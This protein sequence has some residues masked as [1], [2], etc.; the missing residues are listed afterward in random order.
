MPKRKQKKKKR[1]RSGKVRHRHAYT[2]CSELMKAVDLVPCVPSLHF[3]LGNIVQITME[4]AELA[5]LL[6]I[7]GDAS[8]VKDTV[9]G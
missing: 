8:F 3:H 4:R 5:R 2:I 7:V 9:A 1:E 6:P